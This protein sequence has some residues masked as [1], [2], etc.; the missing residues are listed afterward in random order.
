V[1]VRVLDGMQ[2]VPLPMQEPTGVAGTFVDPGGLGAEGTWA[3]DPALDAAL[4]EVFGQAPAA[5]DPALL[6]ALQNI[7]TGE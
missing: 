5:T 7:L 3:S 1:M 6:E 4:Q 2:P